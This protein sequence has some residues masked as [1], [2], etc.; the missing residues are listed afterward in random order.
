MSCT[1]TT[2][3]VLLVSSTK[4]RRGE[5][6]PVIKEFFSVKNEAY[7]ITKRPDHKSSID[8]T[9]NV[10]YSTLEQQSSLINPPVYETINQ[11]NS[12]TTDVYDNINDYM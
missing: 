7:G 10:A 11:D 3:C 1:I 12:K 8:V 5:S 9:E 6:S 2:V 4:Q